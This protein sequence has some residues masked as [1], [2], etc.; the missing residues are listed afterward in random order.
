MNRKC[1]L[2]WFWTNWQYWKKKLGPIMRNIWGRFFSCF[3]L[4]RFLNI[5]LKVL[6]VPSNSFFSPKKTWINR[7]QIGQNSQS[8]VYC[9][10]GDTSQYDFYT[11]TLFSTTYLSRLCRLTCILITKSLLHHSHHNAL[12]F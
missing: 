11:M 9:S 7:S 5:F 2:G 1:D 10:D 8:I 4:Q 3:R 6:Y 12:M